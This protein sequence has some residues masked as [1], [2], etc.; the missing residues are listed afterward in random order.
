MSVEIKCVAPIRSKVGEGPVWDDRENCLWWVD[1]PVGL[2]H[3]YDPATQKN[4]TYE[5]G[6]PVGCLAVRKSGGLVVAAKSGFWFFDPKSDTREAIYNPESNLANNRFNDGT[7]DMQG[8]FWAGTM[9]TDSTPQALGSFYRLDA[10]LSVTKGFGDI[11]TTNGLAFSPDGTRMY[12]SDSN[13]SVRMLWSCEYDPATG[14]P[15]PLEGFFDTRTVPGRPDGGTTDSQGCY[16][17]A[18]VSGWQLYRLA[19][20]GEILMTL[21]MPIEKPTKPMF[22]GKNLDTLFVTSIG[23]GLEND[24]K[25]PDA[26][27]LFTITG[28]EITGIAQTP[29]AG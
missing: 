7:T 24:P 16:W 6:E 19:S 23:D 28:L 21:D 27:G 2:I 9:N 13:P 11:F 10:D 26:G 29:F 17:M 4:I 3:R 8:R 1:I 22:G 12:L 25:Q 5:F 14:T 15:G 20:D 18:G